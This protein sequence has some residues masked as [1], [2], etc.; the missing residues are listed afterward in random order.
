LNSQNI[1]VS[2]AGTAAVQHQ[3]TL[4]GGA[5][6]PPI[7]PNAQ[8]SEFTPTQFTVDT[9]N[10]TNIKAIIATSPTSHGR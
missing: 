10:N 8:I 9:T 4:P 5:S 3:P 1:Y 6:V 2:G 7:D